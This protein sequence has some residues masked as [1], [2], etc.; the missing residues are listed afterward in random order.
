MI[1]SSTSVKFPLVA[2]VAIR[3]NIFE[4]I[5]RMA[6]QAIKAPMCPLER[7]FGVLG[8]DRLPAIGGVTLLAIPAQLHS[9]RRALHSVH[10]AVN[11]LPGIPL[12]LAIRM[13]LAAGKG[14]MDTDP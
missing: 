7:E 9:M 14:L 11:A 4:F 12:K 3:L 13:T 5:T 1:Q 6:I 10:V 8:P 2:R